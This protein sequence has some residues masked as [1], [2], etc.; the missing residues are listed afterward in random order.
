MSAGSRGQRKFIS[1]LHADLE[2]RRSR[3]IQGSLA[4]RPWGHG[5][6]QNLNC[7][8]MQHPHP[9][10]GPSPSHH[11]CKPSLRLQTLRCA[12]MQHTHPDGRPSS[13]NACKP[14]SHHD[15]RPSSHLQS[16]RS[17]GMQHSP[18]DCE[19]SSHNDC[20]SVH[21]MSADLEERQ[22]AAPSS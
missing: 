13:Y 8:G 3:S 2:V 17:T 10:R 1:H 12:S 16:L 9:D 21:V 18:H 6:L 7:T 11:A 20:K 22:R 19:S 5:T 15:G 4:N 14:S